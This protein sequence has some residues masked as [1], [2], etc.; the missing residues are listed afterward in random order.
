MTLKTIDTTWGSALLSSEV[1]RRAF[2]R[3]PVTEV[4]EHELDTFIRKEICYWQPTLIIVVER[5][6]TAIIRALKES[7]RS[8]LDWPWARVI[9][10]QV[11]TER[12]PEFYRGQRILVFD[13]MKKRGYHVFRVLDQLNSMD[14]AILKQVRVAV[15][16][17]HEDATSRPEYPDFGVQHGWFHRGLTTAAYRNKRLEILAM[18]QQAG[19]LMLDTEHFEVRVRLRGPFPDFLHALGRKAHTVTFHSLGSRRNITVFYEDNSP[20]HQLD[21]GRLPARA[22]T[23]DKV[24]KCRIIEC[25]DD[26]FAVIPLCYPAIPD[27]PVGG[28]P[29]N[30][31]DAALLGDA[32]KRSPPAAF[33]GTALISALDVL[34]WVLKALYAAP[35]QLLSVSL[36]TVHTDS[37][38][39]QDCCLNH[40]QV[41]YPTLDLQRLANEIL[42]V[43]TDASR[44]GLQL[45]GQPAAPLSSLEARDD[46]L[47]RDAWALLQVVRHVLDERI[48]EERLFDASWKPPH[49]FA[50][51]ADEVF[52]LGD[53]FGWQ[54]PYTSSL[55]DT[56]IDDGHLVTHAGQK[57]DE[58]GQQYWER[59]FEP[60]GEMVS[61]LVRTYTIQRGLPNGF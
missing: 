49:P 47:R 51:A 29:N 27:P 38:A 19:S 25:G 35:P 22:K 57:V 24:K 15:F 6:G 10:S 45:R 18:L 1:P 56:L 52:H 42:R 3:M 58:Q 43:D 37:T 31:D 14:P 53:R 2:E 34:K 9:S 13:D 26:E 12:A 39:G 40:L 32:I 21:L 7:L 20:A 48:Q 33:Y 59:V 30:P 60:D 4:T 46:E 54:R 5:R 11:L 8:R 61:E 17:M 28:W 41:V 36:P 50:L 16:A 44:E 23:D 55:F